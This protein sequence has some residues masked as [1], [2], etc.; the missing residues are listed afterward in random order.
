MRG[1][2]RRTEGFNLAFLDIMACGLGAIIL[3]F[4][5]VKYQTDQPADELNTLQ[6]EL[7]EQQ[8]ENE[9]IESANEALAAQLA[10]LERDLQQ[11]LQRAAQSDAAAEKSAEEVLALAREIA[12]LQR[13]K[14]AHE[15]RISAQEKPPV[16]A[17]KPQEDHLLGL[18]VSGSRILILLDNS[19]SMAEERLVDIIKIKASDTATKQ[20][21]P[22]WRRTLAV[23]DWILERLPEG[24]EY[25]VIQYNATANFLPDKKWMRNGDASARTAVEQALAALYPQGATNLH[26]ALALIR[27]GGISPTDIYVITDSLPTQ[28]PLSALKKLRACGVGKKNNVSGECR[29][30]LFYSAVQS[31]ARSNSATVNAVLLP[32]EGDPDAAYSYWLWAASTTGTMISPAGSWP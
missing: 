19:A 12:R 1:Q 30:E 2:Q 20:S 8:R 6:S 27:D 32:I 3:V 25:M 23:V 14:S 21:A 24:S 29:R 18:R 17:E 7:A 13:E 5:L 22:K 11:R 15:Q 28:G 26:A 10:L 9:A 4:M 31:F 16:P